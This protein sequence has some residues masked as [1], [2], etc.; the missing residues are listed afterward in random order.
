M[1][2]NGQRKHSL[3]KLSRGYLEELEEREI[4]ISDPAESSDG[5]SSVH[6]LLASHVLGQARIHTYSALETFI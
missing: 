1:S 3:I 6:I 2:L 4:Y 5:G